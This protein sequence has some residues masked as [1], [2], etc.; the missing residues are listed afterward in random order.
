MLLLQLLTEPLPHQLLF[1]D[2]Q[3][4]LEM[5]PQLKVTSLSE[6]VLPPIQDHQGFN[7]Q[8]ANLSFDTNNTQD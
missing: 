6:F 1:K 7:R 2:D 8:M 4:Q 5:L 3:F